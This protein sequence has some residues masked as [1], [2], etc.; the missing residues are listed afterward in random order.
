[1]G[2]ARP[3]C[4]G[5]DWPS[6]GSGR[7]PIGPIPNNGQASLKRQCLGA[8]RA[9][10]SPAA[11]SFS[12]SRA[13]RRGGAGGRV[14]ARAPAAVLLKL[15]TQRSKARQRRPPSA[16]PPPPARLLGRRGRGGRGRGGRASERWAALA[17][18][19]APRASRAH[20]PAARTLDQGLSRFPAGAS[21][22]RPRGLSLL[23]PQPPLPPPRRV[24][25]TPAARPQ[26]SPS[27]P[28]W[29]SSQAHTRGPTCGGARCPAR[30]SA[31]ER[32]VRGPHGPRAAAGRPLPSRRPPPAL[33]A[34]PD[35]RVSPAPHTPRSPVGC[36][37]RG[38]PPRPLARPCGLL[39]TR[40]TRGATRGREKDDPCG[41]HTQDGVALGKRGV[42]RPP[43]SHERPRDA[44][45]LPSC[46]PRGRL[47][48]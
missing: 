25:P 46:R 31:L 36:G 33:R 11:L 32:V 21:P 22:R 38:P 19:G 3:P 43:S 37:R 4:G 15:L 1:M 2:G 42:A 35:H 13:A 20:G 18:G 8:A 24:A 29:A 45:S 9:A 34:P 26:V 6:A 27:R 28:A 12:V 39:Q 5:R 40:A 47:S 16:R 23:P 41:R 14:R 30:A 48:G 44:A 7:F 17:P 10:R